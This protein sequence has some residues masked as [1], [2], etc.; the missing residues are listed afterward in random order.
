MKY[1]ALSALLLA[2]TFTGCE[3]SAV[4]VVDSK[5]RPVQNARVVERTGD[6]GRVYYTNDDGEVSNEKG[7]VLEVSKPGYNGRSIKR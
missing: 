2:F 3:S 4:R 5:G 7:H 6:T 1:L